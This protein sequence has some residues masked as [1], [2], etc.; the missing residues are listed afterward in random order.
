[1]STLRIRGGAAAYIEMVRIV[2]ELMLRRL[3]DSQG[4]Q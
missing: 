2:Y 1:M 4:A 3:W